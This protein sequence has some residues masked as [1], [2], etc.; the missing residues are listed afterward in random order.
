VQGV[1]VYSWNY[2]AAATEALVPCNLVLALI[3]LS[4]N[5]KMIIGRSSV[6]K[7]RALITGF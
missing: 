1:Y 3:S 7:V 6:L 2:P 5:P 4:Q